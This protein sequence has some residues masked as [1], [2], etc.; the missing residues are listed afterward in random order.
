MREIGTT[1]PSSSALVLL[2][3]LAACESS[4]PARRPPPYYYPPP[5][6]GP[7]A[8]PGPPSGNLPDRRPE[9][10]SRG[11]NASTPRFTDCYQ[12][13]E[14][15]MLGKSGTVTIFFDIAPAGQVTRATDVA[16]PGIALPGAPLADPKLA[17]CLS[18]GMLAVRFDPARDS[19][20]A[21]WTFQ[22]SR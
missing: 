4:A 11:V 1:N 19:T 14:S 16:P 6:P 2:V 7:A 5:G 22:F 3:G 12:R 10:I 13:S 18:Q 8:A 15:F 20:A 17:E 9:D 21:S